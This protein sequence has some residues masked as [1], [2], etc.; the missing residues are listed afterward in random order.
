MLH[1]PLAFRPELPRSNRGAARNS[2][3]IVIEPLRVKNGIVRVVRDDLL[4]GGTKQRAIIPYLEELIAR[5]YDDFVYASPFCGYA[6][7]ALASACAELGV[8]ATL[9]CETDQTPGIT[10]GFHPFSERARGLGAEIL[11]VESLDE[12]TRNAREYALSK[13]GAL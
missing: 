12:A 4:P 10:P 3:D 1:S 9:Y 5:G 6:Q 8:K 11:R 7:V 13:P 2:P